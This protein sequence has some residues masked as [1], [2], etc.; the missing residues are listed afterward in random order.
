MAIAFIEAYADNDKEEIEPLVVQEYASYVKEN[1]VKRAVY[2]IEFV[3]AREATNMRE[4]K[5]NLTVEKKDGEMVYCMA[6]IKMKRV[7]A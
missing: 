7:P 6:K 3:S 4:L 2:N 5:F 1:K